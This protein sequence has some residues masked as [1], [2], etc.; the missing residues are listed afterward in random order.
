M[1]TNKFNQE[2]QILFLP[3]NLPSHDHL[4]EL[5][6]LGWIVDTPARCVRAEHPGGEEGS[7]CHLQLYY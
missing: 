5:E 2:D 4:T 6:L 3:N 1:K 7:H